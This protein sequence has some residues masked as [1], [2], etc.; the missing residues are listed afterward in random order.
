MLL[1]NGSQLS[2]I[3]ITILL[4]VVPFVSVGRRAETGRGVEGGGIVEVLSSFYPV[5][6]LMA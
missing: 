3:V 5:Q 1:V 2:G 6:P 4:L